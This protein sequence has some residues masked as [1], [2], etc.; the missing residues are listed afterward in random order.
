LHIVFS[1]KLEWYWI[2][3]IH[4]VRAWLLIKLTPCVPLSV[5]GEGE[6]YGDS[7]SLL[8]SP[9]AGSGQALYEREKLAYPF[10]KGGKRGI[11]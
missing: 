6:E 1:L 8:I 10:G 5:D 4:E 11:I 2:T 3:D 7:K 9:S